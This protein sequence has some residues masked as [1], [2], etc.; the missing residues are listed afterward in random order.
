MAEVKTRGTGEVKHRADRATLSLTYRARAADRTKAT[1]AL[2]AKVGPVEQLLERSGVR[3][4]SRDLFVHDTW[5]GR[6]RSG[7]EAEQ[8]YEVRIADFDVLQELVAELVA[9]EP[10]WLSGP[11][12]E[13]KDRAAATREAQNLAVMDA[14]DRAEGYAAALGARLA[15]LVRIEDEAAGGFDEMAPRLAHGM[16]GGAEGAPNLGELRMEPE[17]VSVRVNCVA[18]WDLV[19]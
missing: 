4:R 9:S 14:R 16:P 5:N 15:R 17:Q 3:I 11:S 8:R 13:L 2:N 7:A 10:A 12:W 19:S 6:R 1:E 18:V